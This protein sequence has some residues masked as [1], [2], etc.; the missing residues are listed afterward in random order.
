M[1]RIDVRGRVVEAYM[2][3]NGPILL[4]LHPEDFFTQHRPFLDQ[5]ARHFRVI[6]PRHPGF[7]QSALP[8]G[9]RTIDDLAYHTLDLVAALRLSDITLV[10]A[11]LGGWIGMEMCVKSTQ[12]I[13]RLVLLGAVGVKFGGREDRDFA[14]LYA[15]PALDVTRLLFHDPDKFIPDY[16]G[17]TDDAALEIARD[18]QSAGYFLWKPYMHN[19]GLRKWL[20]RAQVPALVIS[21][22]QDGFVVHGHAEKLADA[23]PDGRVQMIAN[24]GHYPQIEQTEAV[25]AAITAFAQRGPKSPKEP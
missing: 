19:P 4:F 20:H 8:E 7:G 3:G 16:A 22:A 24:A 23:L 21:G 13:A 14:D 10:G 1:E 17:V 2:A 11:S 9:F 18:R 15:L 6:A 5:L 12:D 25:A